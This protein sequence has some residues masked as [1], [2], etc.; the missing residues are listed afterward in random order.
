MNWKHIHTKTCMWIFIAALFIIFSKWKQSRCHLTG[1]W[2]SKLW[3][4]HTRG[5]YSEIQRNDL[6]IYV[7]KTMNLKH[8]FKTKEPKPHGDILYNSIH[9]TFSRKQS[10]W[11]E[12]RSVLVGEWER[13]MG[14]LPRGNI[15]KFG[16]SWNHFVWYYDG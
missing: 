8:I 2:I 4:F 11:V 14:L 9:L 10:G 12:I 7:D 1:E 5:Y 13:R 16:V 6:L 15:N 3:Y